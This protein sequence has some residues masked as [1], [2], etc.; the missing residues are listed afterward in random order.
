M[1]SDGNFKAKQPE[2]Q[3]Q[4]ACS[5]QQKYKELFDKDCNS[6]KEP[7]N[8][9]DGNSP[10]TR[11]TT[12]ATPPRTQESVLEPAHRRG[13]QRRRNS[14]IVE[15]ER[16]TTKSPY[17]PQAM[18]PTSAHRGCVCVP[19]L[20]CSVTLEIKGNPSLGRPF[21]VGQPPSKKKWGKGVPLNN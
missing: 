20:S 16:G 6:P 13:S 10:S 12:R 4:L 17:P 11:G 1:A 9:R 14:A 5:K 7:R 15:G 3:L 8:R 19:F 2:Y 21:L 18:A